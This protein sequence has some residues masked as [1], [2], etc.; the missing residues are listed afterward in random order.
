MRHTLHA[1]SMLT[2]GRPKGFF[3]CFAF[4][5]ETTCITAGR[6]GHENLI[7]Q[8]IWNASNISAGI[9]KMQTKAAKHL[10]MMHIPLRRVNLKLA[11]LFNLEVHHSRTFIVRCEDQ[12]FYFGNSMNNCSLSSSLTTLHI[13][14]YNSDLSKVDLHCDR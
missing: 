5:R 10:L 14:S 8:C 7:N 13:I 9:I 4:R 11:Y 12:D 1:T 2:G 3:L 6:S